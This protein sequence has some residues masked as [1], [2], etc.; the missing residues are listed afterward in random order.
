MYKDK[1]KQRE[2]NKAA[3]RRYRARRDTIGGHSPKGITPN[4]TVVIPESVIPCDTP[5]VIPAHVIPEVQSIRPERK[6]LTKEAQ[7]RGFN[8]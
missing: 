7:V 5:T 8:L 6:P 3:T 4:A 2:A 1:D